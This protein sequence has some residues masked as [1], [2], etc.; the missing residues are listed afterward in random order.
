M[1]STTFEELFKKSKGKPVFYNGREIKLADEIFFVEKL[2]SINLTF[3]ETGHNGYKQG[4]VLETDGEFYVNEQTIPKKIVLWEDTAPKKLEISFKTNSKK[5]LVYN[6]WR[7]PESSVPIHFWHN[8]AAIQVEEF[9]GGKIY[10]CNDGQAND[11]F[12][13]LVFKIEVLSE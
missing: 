2:A 5:L 1:T 13:D 12:N 11:D 10:H 8:G 4:I 6:A 7:I 3:I 9:S